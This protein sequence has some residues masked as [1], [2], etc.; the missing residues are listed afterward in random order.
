MKPN[1]TPGIAPKLGERMTAIPAIANYPAPHE[2]AK[3]L[4]KLFESD[5]DV[6]LMIAQD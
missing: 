2:P 5:R 4:S 6:A 1:A 3:P